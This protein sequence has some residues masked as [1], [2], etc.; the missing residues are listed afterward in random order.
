MNIRAWGNRRVFT[1]APGSNA[2][3]L[4]SCKYSDFFTICRWH[5]AVSPRKCTACRK[6]ADA[7][8]SNASLGPCFLLHLVACFSWSQPRIGI[9]FRFFNRGG[10]PLVIVDECRLLFISGRKVQPLPCSVMPN[11]YPIYFF[12]KVSIFYLPCFAFF[13]A[14]AFASTSAQVLLVLSSP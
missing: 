8:K 10:M 7:A 12:L 9:Y 11:F 13:F 4:S 6:E 14:V 5:I 1:C 3:L 2:H